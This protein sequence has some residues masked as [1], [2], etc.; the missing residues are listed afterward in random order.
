MAGE[1]DL[2]CNKIGE[3]IRNMWKND[4]MNVIQM[5]SRDVVKKNDVQMKFCVN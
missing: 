2:L 5:L 1:G 3:S 4:V